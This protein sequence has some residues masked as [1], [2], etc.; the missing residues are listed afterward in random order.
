MWAIFVS[1]LSMAEITRNFLEILLIK[2]DQDTALAMGN[3]ATPSTDTL[4]VSRTAS[5]SPR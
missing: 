3:L 5:E 1:F 2:T 4:E